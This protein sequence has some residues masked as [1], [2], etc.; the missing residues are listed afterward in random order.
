MNGGTDEPIDEPRRL[1]DSGARPSAQM[2]RAVRHVDASHLA[3]QRLLRRAGWL[4]LVS[5]LSSYSRDA[6]AALSAKSIAS[7]AGVGVAAGV[8]AGVTTYALRAPPPSPSPSPTL[9]ERPSTVEV[10]PLTSIPPPMAVLDEVSVEEPQGLGPEPAAPIAPKAGQS[11]KAM[12]PLLGEEIKLFDSAR[13][14]VRNAQP[15][16]ALSRLDR[17]GQRFPNGRFSLEASALRIEALAAL[18]KRAQARTLAQRFIERHPK[19]LLVERV[20]PYAAGP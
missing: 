5:L 7:L 15:G 8:A 10:A 9:F 2:I 18:G 1:A 13:S 12:E 19:S 20:R 14:A 6:A 11:R 3:K 16:E 17:Y 4:S